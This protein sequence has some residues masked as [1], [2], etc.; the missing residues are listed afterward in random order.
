MRLRLRGI[1]LSLV[2]GY[3]SHHPEVKTVPKKVTICFSPQFTH[4]EEVWLPMKMA[5]L[6]QA[7]A[8]RGARRKQAVVPYP[9]AGLAAVPPIP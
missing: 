2:Q 7:R 8:P 3:R 1:I 5:G 6:G 9:S 4:V